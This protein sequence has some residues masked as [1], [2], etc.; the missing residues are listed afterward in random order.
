M[1]YNKTFTLSYQDR[2]AAE[3]YC[4]AILCLDDSRQFTLRYLFLKD[5]HDDSDYQSLIIVLPPLPRFPMAEITIMEAALSVRGD[6]LLITY[7]ANHIHYYAASI[8]LRNCQE[9]YNISLKHSALKHSAFFSAPAPTINFN[10]GPKSLQFFASKQV[11]TTLLT[12]TATPLFEQFAKLPLSS[13][14]KETVRYHLKQYSG[15]A[16]LSLSASGK[17]LSLPLTIG[18][19]HCVLFTNTGAD[20]R[21]IIGGTTGSSFIEIQS[22][23]L[24][25]LANNIRL[26]HVYKLSIDPEKKYLY[27]LQADRIRVIPVELL[28]LLPERFKQIE[29]YIEV[30]ALPAIA[31]DTPPSM[32]AVSTQYLAYSYNRETRFYLRADA[33]VKPEVIATFP[34][35]FSAHNIRYGNIQLLGRAEVTFANGFQYIGELAVFFYGP[36]SLRDD[37][38]IF[39]HFNGSSTFY[40]PDLSTIKAALPIVASTTAINGGALLSRRCGDQF[41]ITSSVTTLSLSFRGLDHATV[42]S[43]FLPCKPLTFDS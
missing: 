31:S 30:L 42:H 12:N 7:T 15:V 8:T 26:T 27:L 32:L 23:K 34:F 43:W 39:E 36:D 33:T 3:Q 19:P 11:A 18:K 9:L 35:A 37:K 21:A 1:L 16:T 40:R 25:L 22:E 2:K 14:L 28:L 6:S 24:C 5:R 4:A 41:L 17:W 13:D 29:A 38:Y 10:G 20:I